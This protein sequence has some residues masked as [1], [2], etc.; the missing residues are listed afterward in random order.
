MFFL[1]KEKDTVDGALR[2][3][4]KKKK[5]RLGIQA[6]ALWGGNWELNNKSGGKNIL[7][8]GQN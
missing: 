7:G 1:K 2:L 6:K 3:I 8:R 4:K 5:K